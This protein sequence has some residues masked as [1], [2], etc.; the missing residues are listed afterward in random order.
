LLTEKKNSL[1]EEILTNSKLQY[2]YSKEL[3]TEKLERKEKKKNG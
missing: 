2:K 1:Q 3:V